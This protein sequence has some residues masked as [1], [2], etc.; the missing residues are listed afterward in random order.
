MLPSSP[1][2]THS[3]SATTCIAHNVTLQHLIYNLIT[4][5]TVYTL[6]IGII[7]IVFRLPTDIQHNRD[8]HCFAFC[9]LIIY[10]F[11]DLSYSYFFA[12][13]KF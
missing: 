9:Q 1:E 4:Y 7:G 10:L 11:V 5:Y 8:V 6:T 3:A 2:T 13:S 12:N